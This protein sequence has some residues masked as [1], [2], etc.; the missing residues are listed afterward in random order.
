MVNFG[1]ISTINK[2]TCVTDHSIKTID[3]KHR[4]SILNTKIQT[5]IIETISWY[6]QPQNAKLIWMMIK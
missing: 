4:E 5:R 6:F 2:T 3:H 1:M